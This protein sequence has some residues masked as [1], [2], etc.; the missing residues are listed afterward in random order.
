MN[1]IRQTNEKIQTTAQKRL[2]SIDDC[3]WWS[4]FSEKRF[5]EAFRLFT[6]HRLNEYLQIHGKVGDSSD[7][8]II[9]LVNHFLKTFAPFH[10]IAFRLY[11]DAWVDYE[12]FLLSDYFHPSKALAKLF[13]VKVSTKQ[14][15]IYLETVYNEFVTFILQTDVE[16]TKCVTQGELPS[17]L[18]AYNLRE[19]VLSQGTRYDYKSGTEGDEGCSQNC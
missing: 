4:R 14:A 17:A 13:D 12:C 11:R 18:S 16:I 3:L 1:R 6:W 19:D 10:K 9:M 7:L 5:R 8:K 2:Y 15:H